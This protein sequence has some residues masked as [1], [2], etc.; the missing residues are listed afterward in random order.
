MRDFTTDFDHTDPTFSRHLTTITADLRKRCPLAHGNAHGGFWVLSRHRDIKMIL[1]DYK[2]F[3]SQKDTVIPA[4]TDQMKTLPFEADPPQ[5][6]LYRHLLTSWLSMQHIHRYEPL[7]RRLINEQI[8]TFIQ[9]GACDFILSLAIPFPALVIARVIGLSSQEAPVFANYLKRILTSTTTDAREENLKARQSLVHYLLRKLGR[10]GL[11]PR[12]DFL[13][14][15]ATSQLAGKPLTDEER[16]NLMISLIIASY[17]PMVEALGSLLLYLAEHPDDRQQLIANPALIPLTIEENFRYHSPVQ[18]VGRHIAHKSV[19]YQ[20]ELMP[21]EKIFLLLGS[22]NH[23]ETQFPDAER[24]HLDRS[25][26]RHIAFGYG[27][28]A[29]PGAPLARLEI[30][31]AIEEILRRLP[32]YHLAGSAS[33]GFPT[34]HIY[35]VERLP[36]TFSPSEAEPFSD[37]L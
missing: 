28:H 37:H 21:G 25:P 15:L 6:S 5:H 32:D 11:Q 18:Y 35:G 16:I 26:N 7:I 9:D 24:F 34:G 10:R 19:I 8:D 14:L 22:A 30:R 31:I 4:R 1:R 33:Y 3:S 29:C 17:E 13:S 27:I 23:D 2:A 20:Q 12:D 36:V